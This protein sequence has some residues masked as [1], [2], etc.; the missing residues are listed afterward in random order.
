LWTRG[1]L[2]PHLSNANAMFYRYTTSPI[3]IFYLSHGKIFR[4]VDGPLAHLVERFYGIEEVV[5]SSPIGSTICSSYMEELCVLALF[6]IS[7][8]MF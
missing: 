4:L 6:V 5:G 1:E 8:E 3:G 7:Y 2:N